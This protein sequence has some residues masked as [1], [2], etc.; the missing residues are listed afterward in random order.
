LRRWSEKTLQTGMRGRDP[1]CLTS[2][3]FRPE[4]TAT[5]TRPG[6]WVS[7]YIRP[8]GR[9]YFGEVVNLLAAAF[10][11]LTTSAVN[12]PQHSLRDSRAWVT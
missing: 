12:G 5:K 9:T 7:S 4:V 11:L 8:N 1:L 6:G 10:V 2:G 3:E